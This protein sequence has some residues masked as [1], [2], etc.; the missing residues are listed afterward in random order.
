MT[1]SATRTSTEQSPPSQSHIAF[2]IT[3]P[4]HETLSRESIPVTSNAPST[5]TPKES[6]HEALVDSNS[7]QHSPSSI[8]GRLR[9]ASKRFEES[10]LPLGMW[11][12]TGSLASSVPSLS[13]IR[14]GSYGSEGWSSEGQLQ[15]IFRRA[16]VTRRSSQRDDMISVDSRGH[17]AIETTTSRTESRDKHPEANQLKA[18][19]SSNGLSDGTTS[20]GQPKAIVPGHQYRTEPFDNGYQFPPKH[21]WSQA[22]IIGLKAFWQFFLTP[23]GF[24]VVVYGCNVVAWGGMLFLLLCNAS[25]AMCYPTCDDINSPRRVWVEID[26]QVVNAL[27]CVTGFGLI[28]WRFRDLYYLLKFR[29]QKD[30]ISLRRLAGIHRGWFRLGGSQELPVTLG[31]DE[32]ESEFANLSP[33]TIPYP[34]KSI[35]DAPLTGIRAPP[36][37]IWKLDYVIWMY[38]WNT[39]L[40]GVLSGIMWGLNRY[41]RPSWTTGLF[42]ALASIVAA[43][44][45][46]TVFIEGKKVKAVEGIPVSPEDQ[47]QLMRDREMG[48]VHFNNLKG[49]K[50]KEG[51]RSDRLFRKTGGGGGKDR[52]T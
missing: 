31:P 10:N 13:D 30:E 17:P 9:S 18:D 45:G 19:Q 47:E 3:L 48:I 16:S 49:E 6:R 34:L 4:S 14:R 7:T 25:L 24:L 36:T 12:A 41:D 32:I 11:D 2:D 42:V 22:C 46:I 50:P 51:T 38:V 44:G 35:P 26:S 40:Q 20:I 8:V 29:L 33:G 23:L 39:F 28:P 5:S 52:E 21:S 43:L 37:P 15:E 1:A 27:F